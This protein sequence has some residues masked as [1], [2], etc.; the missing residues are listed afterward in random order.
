MT[1][2][3]DLQ[4]YK[5]YKQITETKTDPY[6]EA[7]ITYVST[8]VENYCNRKFVEYASSPGV[9]E[10]HSALTNRVYLNHFPVLEVYS[11]ETSPDSGNTYTALSEGY[12]STNDGYLVDY[13][14][15]IIMTQNQRTPFLY[16]CDLEYNSFKVSYRAGY[17]TEI[18]SD[19]QL[20]IFDLVHY[21]EHEESSVRKTM[22]G[23]TLENPLAFNDVDFPAHIKRILSLYRAPVAEEFSTQRFGWPRA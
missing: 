22:M 4:D 20:A 16:S 12:Q 3:V 8:L 5:E 14:N 18:P 1:S 21:Y 11:V 23:A 17:E 7:L 6:R 2:L 9:I 13:E 10:Y 19:L 15:A